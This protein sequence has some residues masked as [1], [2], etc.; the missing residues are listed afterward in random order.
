VRRELLDDGAVA[1]RTDGATLVVTRLGAGAVLI[2]L[3]GHDRGQ[4]GDAPF[5]ELAGELARH[6]AI[7][8]FVDTRS[9]QSASGPVTGQWGTWIHAN[10]RA[11]RRMSVLVGSK[12][13]ELTAELVRF[14]SRAPHLVRIYTDPAAFGD[15]IGAAAGRPYVLGP[16]RAA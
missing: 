15:A 9:A 3:V 8:I 6:E 2:E 11:L 12:Y 16:P 4:F 1:L 13:V 14:F 7:E 5:A 10:Q